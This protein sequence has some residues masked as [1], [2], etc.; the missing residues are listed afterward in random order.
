MLS[1]VISGQVLRAEVGYAGATAML[2]VLLAWLYR[3]S[4]PAAAA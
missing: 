1:P 3:H 2:A 4:S